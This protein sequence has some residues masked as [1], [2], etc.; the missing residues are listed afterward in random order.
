M[1]QADVASVL[2]MLESNWTN[3]FSEDMTE[4]GNLSTAV[5]APKDIVEDLLSAQTKGEK[6]YND[7]KAERLCVEPSKKFHDPLP[8][9]QL[10]T[11]ANLKKSKSAKSRGKEVLLQTEQ[12]GPC[13]DT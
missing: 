1:K 4:L 5:S 3:P 6:A 2:Q 7:F 12:T 11:F 8:R 10:K 9:L 13:L